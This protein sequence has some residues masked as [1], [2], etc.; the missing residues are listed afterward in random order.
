MGKT[1]IQTIGPLY[2]EVVNGT[3]YGR[4]NGSVY[5]PPTN[6]VS[7]EVAEAVRFIKNESAAW[8]TLCNES[9]TSVGYPGTR[10]NR[11]F[12][13]AQSQ[14]SQNYIGIEIATD[15]DFSDVIATWNFTAGQFNVLGRAFSTS[16]TIVSGTTY[17]L[18]AILYSA[19]GVAVSVS[20]TI[21]MEGYA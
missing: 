10:D 9:G 5:V 7:A 18:R 1:I 16:A 19:S 14:D 17:Y 8:L 20:D 2:G 11:V 13:V 12:V 15:S 4:P 6:T 3:V 21:E